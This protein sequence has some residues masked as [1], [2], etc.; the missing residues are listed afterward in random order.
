M[1]CKQTPVSPVIKYLW[2]I[3]LWFDITLYFDLSSIFSHKNSSQFPIFK[4]ACYAKDLKAM[5]GALHKK[6][7]SSYKNLDSQMA[8]TNNL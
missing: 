3:L 4:P 5:T 8:N 7:Q 1:E 2:V 6:H